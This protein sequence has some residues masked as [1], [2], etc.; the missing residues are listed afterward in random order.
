MSTTNSAVIL[1][2]ATTCWSPLILNSFL[3]SKYVLSFE[4]FHLLSRTFG[5]QIIFQLINDFIN[6]NVF[7]IL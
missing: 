4:S 3:N 6:D 7:L 5:L 2:W 1:H